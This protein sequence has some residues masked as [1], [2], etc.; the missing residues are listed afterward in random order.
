M[1]I[2]GVLFGVLSTG[3]TLPLVALG[4]VPTTT[5]E[6]GNDVSMD[7]NAM[8]M[9]MDSNASTM[10]A[11]ILSAEAEA[12]IAVANA[13]IAAAQAAAEASYQPPA[14][15]YFRH[16]LIGVTGTGANTA[17]VYVDSESARSTSGGSRAWQTVWSNYTPAGSAPGTRRQM[18]LFETACERDQMR[19]IQ[20]VDYGADGRSLGGLTPSFPS[21]NNVVPGSIGE[22]AFRFLCHRS[23]ADF[24]GVYDVEVDA[25]RNLPVSASP[26]SSPRSRSRRRGT[27]IN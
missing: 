14:P 11:D 7:A 3:L 6:L 21:W 27:W 26:R 2:K 24:I 23:R 13:D 17:R 12:A 18:I 9:G 15:T 8:D 19:L 5:T 4:Q 10:S 16:Y 20:F 22:A 1:T 25:R